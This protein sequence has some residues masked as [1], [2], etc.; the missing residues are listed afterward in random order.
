MGK[1]VILA[2]DQSTAGTKAVVFDRQARIVA[3]VL[4]PHRQIYPRPGYV[5][6]DP[7]EIIVNVCL[8]MRNAVTKAGLAFADVA[9]IALSN[10]RESVMVWDRDSGRPL[11][12]VLVWQDGRAEEICARVS[13]ERDEIRAVTGLEP[14]PYF[15]APKIAWIL[16]NVP[17]IKE[18]ARRGQAVFGTMDSYVL[19]RLSGGARHACDVTNASR[20]MLMELSTCTWSEQMLARFDIPAAMAPEIIPSD[21]IAGYTRGLAADGIPDGIPIAAMIGDSHGALFAQCCFAPGMAKATY[22]TGSSV[23]MN[24][25]KKDIRSRFGLVSSVAYARGGEITYC[26]EGNINTTGG[27][28]K[29]MHESLGILPEPGQAGVIAAGLPDNGGVYL[30]PALAGLA[31]PHWRSDVRAAF[32]GMSAGATAAHLIRAGEEA[33]AYQIADVIFAMSRD[34]GAPL[35]GLRVDGGPTRDAFLMKFQA[36]LLGCPVQSSQIAELSAQG[37]AFIA[38]LAIGYWQDLAEIAA[39]YQAGAAYSPE[40]SGETAS[41]LYAGWQQALSTILGNQ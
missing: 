28:T 31:A 20:T 10:Q 3:K 4:L 39:L 30:V 32:V 2:V 11:Y 6:H 41:R 13:G 21:E 1:S 14:S 23:M 18:K 37:A 7:E 8:A 22:G 15:S 25:G 33:I 24:V 19:W 36:G 40:M 17:G 29:W 35:A 26:L 16:E 38:G 12:H 34:M 27:I 5:E 9:A